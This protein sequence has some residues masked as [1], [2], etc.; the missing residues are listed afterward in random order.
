MTNSFAGPSAPAT[1]CMRPTRCLLRTSKVALYTNPARYVSRLSCTRPESVALVGDEDVSERFIEER[2]G[3]QATPGANQ[4]K[5]NS[6]LLTIIPVLGL[7]A[8]LGGGY[9]HKDDIPFLLTSFVELVEK[10]GSWGYLAYAGLYISL[11]VLCIPAVPLTMTAGVIFGPV[12]G[13]AMVSACS[14]TAAT[15]AFLIARY[16]ARD[17]VGNVGGTV[18]RGVL[19]RTRGDLGG[20]VLG[21]LV[22]TRGS[23]SAVSW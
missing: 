18:L 6:P 23:W 19:M 9:T 7:L 2:Q 8:L 11:D 16:V 1:P 20:A 14:T 3:G 12:A 10:L 17:K 13:T 22:S 21:F 5:P 4:A 15:I